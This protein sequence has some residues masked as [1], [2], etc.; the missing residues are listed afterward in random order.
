MTLLQVRRN[1]QITIP[2]KLRQALGIKVGDYIDA[3]LQ[4]EA[5]VL[6]PQEI[7]DLSLAKRKE[8]SKRIFFEFVDRIRE[9]NKDVDPT[10]VEALINEAVTAVRAE[11]RY[12]SSSY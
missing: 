8:D 6:K 2:A 4:D 10:E 7:I 11:E 9:R 3:E 1:F 12:D 5:I